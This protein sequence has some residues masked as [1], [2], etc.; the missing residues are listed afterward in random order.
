MY[1]HIYI[2]IY[3]ERSGLRVA[4][5]RLLREDVEEGP[6]LVQRD[7]VHCVIVSCVINLLFT[8]VVMFCVL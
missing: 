1:I 2:Y 5:G 4:L 7:L 6:D 8:H 3:C